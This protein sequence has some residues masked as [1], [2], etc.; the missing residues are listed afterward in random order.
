M[1]IGYHLPPL[2][3]GTTLRPRVHR[4]KENLCGK[5]RTGYHR[6]NPLFE[7]LAQKGIYDT[8][9]DLLDVDKLKTADLTEP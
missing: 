7:V 9:T 6:D 3:E 5:L 4:I 8:H 2:H 1:N